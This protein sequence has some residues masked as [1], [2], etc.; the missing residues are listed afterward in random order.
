MDFKIEE[1]HA[2]EG[3]R[4]IQFRI[5]PDPR[6]YVRQEAGGKVVYRDRYLNHAIDEREMMPSCG[7]QTA[8]MP[9]HYLTTSIRSAPDY[10]TARK[11]ALM[12]ELRDGGY[13]PPDEEAAKHR[14]LNADTKW[15]VFLS[16]DICGATALRRGNPTGFENAYAIFL[17]ELGTVV[18]QF[19]GTIL[20]TTGDGFIAYLDHPAFAQQCDRAIDMGLTLQR[21]LRDSINPALIDAGLPEIQV[22]V[23][24]DCGTAQ[25]RSLCVPLTGF[26][27][28]EVASNALNLAVKIEESAGSGE[29]LIGRNLYELIHVQWLERAEEVTFDGESVGIPGYKTYRIS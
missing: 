3:G 28:R 23:G 9:L 17:R 11:R 12:A 13:R 18:G 22:R 2:E 25:I 27:T 4:T 21:V 20:K 26:T 5:V 1:L 24:G 19:G 10:A 8:G 6:R 29:F 7:A 14:L 16:V 15:L